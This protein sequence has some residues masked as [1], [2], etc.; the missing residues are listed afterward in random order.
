[1]VRDRRHTTHTGKLFLIAWV[2]RE[3][4]APV[5]TAAGRS[6]PLRLTLARPNACDPS[7]PPESCEVHVTIAIDDA[8]FDHERRPSEFDSR[9]VRS[10]QSQAMMNR[11]GAPRRCFHISRLQYWLQTT[12][13]SGCWGLPGYRS[14]PAPYR[15][16]I[17]STLTS[18]HLSKRPSG[19]RSCRNR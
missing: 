11:S 4:T 13:R 8:D 9:S 15:R 1:M 2:A 17:R 7:P 3:T 16:N 10:R 12:V 5:P 6:R 14:S 18:N 19:Y